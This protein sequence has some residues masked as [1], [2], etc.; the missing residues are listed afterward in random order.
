MAN[1]VVGLDFGTSTTLVAVRDGESLPRVIPIGDVTSWMPSVVGVDNG[2]L[3]VGESA[4]RL[5]PKKSIRSI[6]SLLSSGVSE[7]DIGGSLVSVRDA[8]RALAQ[9]AMERAKRSVPGLLEGAQVYVGCPALWTGVERR[10]LVDVF[11]DCG[12]SVDIGE[13]ID[14]P[15]A[16]GLHWV[17][18]Q[19]R[20]HGARLTGKAAIFDAGGGTLDI[21]FIEVAGDDRPVMTVLSAEGLAESGDALDATIAAYIVPD[22]LSPLDDPAFGQLVREFARALKEDLSSNE[23]ASATL[24]AP[25]G[26]QLKLSRGELEMVFED[27]LNRALGLMKSTIGGALLRVDPPLSP[28]EIRRSVR[29]WDELP[30]GVDHVALVGGLSQIPSVRNALSDIFPSAAVS[31]VDRPQESVVLG[32]T[33]GDRLD[34]LNLPRPPVDFFITLPENESLVNDGWLSDNRLVYGAFS[35]LYEPHELMQGNFRLGFER[36]IPPPPELK[37]GFEVVLRCL[38]PT[39]GRETV[40]FKV[41][42]AGGSERPDGI[43]LIH[44]GSEPIYFK[45]YTDGRFIFRTSKGEIEARVDRWPSLRGP[46]QGVDR[47]IE[48]RRIDTPAPSQYSYPWTR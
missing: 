13:V 15:I 6:K 35:K 44:D 29:E 16:A 12:L 40:K 9:E 14:E 42:G 45:L 28:D 34:E 46:N 25:Y 10:L 32:L 17:N 18:E 30:A 11:H 36:K 5:G 3:V 38:M 1:R 23:N 2:R 43:R 21:A 19:W 31:L 26:T 37:R 47:F 8:V 39:R 41:Q 22:V 7:V 33:Y 20:K 48:M 24:P 27:Q 4:I